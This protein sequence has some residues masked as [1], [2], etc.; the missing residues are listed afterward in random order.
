MPSLGN[1]LGDVTIGV[2][3]GLPTGISLAQRSQALRQQ[4]NQA[5]LQS[6]TTLG[7]I[8]K[9]DVPESFKK[10]S[11]ADLG[12]QLHWDDT[13]IATFQKT[14]DEE[15]QQSIGFL[16]DVYKQLG[17]KHGMDLE[18]VNDQFKGNTSEM[19]NYMVNVW[20]R[21]QTQQ[22]QE[23]IQQIQQGTTPLPPS[24]GAQPEQAPS[25]PMAPPAGGG[26]MGE[27]DR[28]NR[29]EQQI[30]ADPVLASSPAGKEALK[31]IQDRRSDLQQQAQ[32][33]EMQ[34]FRI[35]RQQAKALEPS[36]P[37]KDLLLGQGIT[38]PQPKDIARA[39][40]Q[41]QANKAELAKEQGRARAVAEAERISPGAAKQLTGLV[42]VLKGLR[43]LQA[44]EKDLDAWVGFA[45][46]RQQRFSQF[47]SEDPRYQDFL[48]KLSKVQQAIIFSRTEGGG[49]ALT[50]TELQFLLDV[51]PN[52]LAVGGA[53]RFKAN[54]KNFISY[55]QSKVQGVV[56]FEGAPR[57]EI[58]Q[59]ID[60][61]VDPK[62]A[63]L[64]KYGLSDTKKK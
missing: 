56:R 41:V 22:N 6:L 52:D 13:M 62:A 18:A 45:K 32:F 16:A 37:I 2:S 7:N 27:I 25:A 29:A 57:T 34:R 20:K 48:S 63:L 1:I 58:Q 39:V 15:R 3:Q 26:L 40:Q 28:L 59:E 4:K 60:M 23:R 33:G 35:E 11:I 42:P 53:S 55:I 31:R 61:I 5:F 9:S 36:Q 49:G 8:L 30:N 44:F 47:L 17:L 43:E 24:S 64:K 14:R 46:G 54:I 21:Q 12:P 19:V 38:N 50:P 10:Q 51:V